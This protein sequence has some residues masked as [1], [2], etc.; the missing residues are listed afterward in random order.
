MNQIFNKQS[1]VVID[2]SFFL[3][4]DGFQGVCLVF[5]ENAERKKKDGQT[6]MYIKEDRRYYPTVG[7]ALKRYLEASLN[8][9]S[10]TMEEILEN[11]NKALEVV[12]NF[13]KNFK[14]WK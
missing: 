3:E 11:T 8:K 9:P 13:S 2:D 7:M 5:A 12:E 10:E 14:N 4:P 1:K 6:E